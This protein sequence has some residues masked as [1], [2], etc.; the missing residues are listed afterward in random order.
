MRRPSIQQPV[1]VECLSARNGLTTYR[2][3]PC[4]VI[5]E[6]WEALGHLQARHGIT[7]AD[8]N[9]LLLD[10]LL[11]RKRRVT[12]SRQPPVWREL[13]PEAAYD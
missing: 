10:A 6:P 2:C 7:T 9:R 12:D 8:G 13:V 4:Q 3:T 11:E 1:T 5:V